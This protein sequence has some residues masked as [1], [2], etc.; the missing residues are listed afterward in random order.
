[1]PSLTGTGSFYRT[2]YVLGLII[3]VVFSPAYAHASTLLDSLVSF[4]DKLNLS[5]Y[6]KNETAFRYLEPRSFT[7]I[8]NIAYVRGTYA[9]ND[10]AEITGA[11]WA[12]YDLAY[13]LFDYDTISARAKRDAIQPLNF[14]NNLAERT[15]SGVVD[16]RELYLDL[17]LENADVRIGRQ[18][19]I[20]GV[21]TGVRIVDELNPMN[22]RELIL[23]DLLDYRIPLW[24]VRTNLYLDSSELQFVWIP[25]IKF[26]KPAPPGSEWELLQE[27]PGTVYPDNFTL[28]NS[29]FGLRWRGHVMDAEVSLS[30]FYTWDDFPVIFRRI[31]IL[32]TVVDGTVAQPVF[33]PRYTRMHMYGAT[34][35]RQIGSQI[36]K[37]E[38]AYV[39]GK[40]F[41]LSTVDR[42]ND[43]ILDNQ[44]ELKRDHI[45]W[46]L[47][48]DFNVWKT[49][50]SP[51][52][53]QWIVLDYDSALIQPKSDAA[54]NL[55][56]RKELPDLK[57]VFQML[58]LRMIT[59][60]ELYIK[61]KI[62]FNV[63]DLFEISAGLDLLYGKSSQAGV[64]AKDGKA[65]DIV[66]IEQ[67]YQFLGNFAGNKRIFVEFKY[68][69]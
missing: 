56:L 67:R 54:F 43:G 8:R 62:T 9:I 33:F 63:T 40:Y 20:W 15:D 16:L 26:H 30:Y 65:V 7:K 25:E 22:F 1:M 6:L 50:I 48:T 31:P 47:G 21:L 59:L 39:T 32:P 5:G 17:F 28:K 14:I 60:D 4:R 18:F 10:M 34:I 24:S 58:V 66:E 53:T 12:Y 23:P 38:I 41:G 11:A 69:F 36:I 57:A 29:E 45:R 64:A 37:G 42:N 27:V 61:P 51:G 68:S 35:Q 55:F 52:V 44:G 2:P 3:F 46:G 13:N 19:I 49:D